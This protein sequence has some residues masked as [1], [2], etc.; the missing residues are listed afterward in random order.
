MNTW[1]NEWITTWTDGWMHVWLKQDA[2]EI[3]DEWK[4]LNER[5][6]EQM[7]QEQLNRERMM[8]HWLMVLQKLLLTYGMN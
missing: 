3:S 4:R 2:L 7:N 8:N 5:M 1:V 6:I